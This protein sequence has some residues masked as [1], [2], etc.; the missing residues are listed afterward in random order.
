MPDGSGY[1]NGDLHPLDQFTV[2]HKRDQRL[3]ADQTTGQRTG[4][5]ALKNERGDVGVKNNRLHG[6]DSGH[7]AMT[8]GMGEGATTG[9]FRDSG[10]GWCTDRRVGRF[11][12]GLRAD[13]GNLVV[14]CLGGQGCS[15]TESGDASARPHQLACRPT[16]AAHR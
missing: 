16:D 12:C 4:E 11:A 7:V 14:G 8:L 1:P 13:I 2:R 5:L 3:P 10:R 9:T 15:G 6:S